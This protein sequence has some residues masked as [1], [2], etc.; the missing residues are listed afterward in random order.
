M[1]EPIG[2]SNSMIMVYAGKFGSTIDLPFEG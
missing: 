2:Q 1:I